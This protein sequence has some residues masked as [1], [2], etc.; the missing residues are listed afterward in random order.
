VPRLPVV[1]L[2]PTL[3]LA[4]LAADWPRFRGPNGDGVANDPGVPVTWTATENV[5]WKVPV[6]GVG[7]SSPV[8]SNGRVFLTSFLPESNERVLLCFD[9]T[10]GKKV[11]QKTVVTA[12]AEKMH[13]NNTP[14]SSTPV[15]DGSRVWSA[16]LDGDAVAVACHDF[17]GEQQWRKLFPGFVSHHGFCGTPVLFENLLIVNGDS[18]GDAFVAALDGRTGETVWKTPRPNRTRSFSVPIFIEVNGRAQMVLAGSKSVAGFDPHT[19]KQLWVADSPTDKF[20]ASA[21]FADGLV[22]ATGTSPN[23]SLAAIDPSGTGNVTKTH[24][25]WFDAKVASYVPSPLAFG[26]RLFVLTDGGIA[27]LFEAKTGKKVWSERLGARLVH[28][29]PLL[30]NGLIY[31][32]A[33]DGTTFVLKAADEFEVV[34]KNPLGEE[35]HAT[36]AVSGGQ[37]FVRSA[38]HLWCVGVKGR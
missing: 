1:V 32:L 18:D 22:F 27:T 13:K 15:A 26:D 17:A 8:V 33:D 34:A 24:V 6:P 19:G 23:N 25:K 11:W 37:L 3:A 38:G 5:L 16:F 29:S 4:L 12:P 28:A 9:R 21:A 35:C 30:V 36:P 2:T 7:H 14:A 31:C 20:V 10:G